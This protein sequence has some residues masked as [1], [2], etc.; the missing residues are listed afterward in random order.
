MIKVIV[1]CFVIYIL[2]GAALGAMSFLGM[3]IAAEEG[4]PFV[5]DSIKELAEIS[6]KVTGSDPNT[7]LRKIFFQN[8]I[9]WP[10]LIFGKHRSKEELEADFDK[11][12]KLSREMDENR[13]AVERVM[14]EAEGIR[15]IMDEAKKED[16]E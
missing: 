7:T 3:K 10:R 2:I 13:N 9:L 15:T 12:R 1:V 16:K 8:M 4:D 11:V 5:Y 14:K 6:A